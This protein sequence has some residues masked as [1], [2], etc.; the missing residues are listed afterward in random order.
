MCDADRGNPAVDEFLHSRPAELRALAS[1]CQRPMSVIRYLSAKCVN[2]APIVRDGIVGGI[3]AHHAAQPRPLFGDWSMPPSSKLFL[4]FS[5]FRSLS[6][7]HGPASQLHPTAEFCPQMW[8]KPKK[9]KVSGFPS[10]VHTICSISCRMIIWRST[11]LV[12]DEPQSEGMSADNARIASRSV[13]TPGCF[14]ITRLCSCCRAFYSL[15]FC[16]SCRSSIRATK[17][18][19][20]STTVSCLIARFT[21]YGACSR[22]RTDS[23]LSMTN[24]SSA[25]SN[26]SRLPRGDR[27]RAYEGTSNGVQD[28]VCFQHGHS[29]SVFASH[30]LLRGVGAR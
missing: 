5:E 26:D 20:G 23:S 7:G 21:S 16:S 24:I 27:W 17:R 25:L 10:T 18:F 12:V 9:S 30:R 6:I 22:K 29:K 4:H 1:G 19:Y 14:A 2:L 13:R 28:C 15:S 3:P 11:V 8:V